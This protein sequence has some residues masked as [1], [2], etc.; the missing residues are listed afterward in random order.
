MPG[1]DFFS[2]CISLIMLQNFPKNSLI[3]S[4][5]LLQ[6]LCTV[7][8]CSLVT[9]NQNANCHNKHEIF[10]HKRN[11]EHLIKNGKRFKRSK[12]SEKRYFSRSNTG[13]KA[14]SRPAGRSVGQPVDL[15][16]SVTGKRK[17][18]A[19]LRTHRLTQ[20]YNIAPYP[21]SPHPSKSTMVEGNTFYGVSSIFTQALRCN[22]E[23]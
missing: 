22:C 1:F 20:F 11:S 12:I 23:N 17:K 19:C 9:F 2:A 3:L 8:R 13:R 10:P 16:D 4:D 5:L 7:S 6:P 18:D 14:N 15:L 21:R